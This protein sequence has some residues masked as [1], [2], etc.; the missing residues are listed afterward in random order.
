MSRA[1]APTA[2]FRNVERKL[3]RFFFRGL[4]VAEAEP[5]GF[6]LGR[7]PN[8]TATRRG[9][10]VGL[11]FG[12]EVPWGV[13]LGLGPN[14][15]LTGLGCRAG[16]GCGL[17]GAL[18]LSA[19]RCLAVSASASSMAFGSR[20][21]LDGGFIASLSLASILGWLGKWAGEGHL[22]LWTGGLK[23]AFELRGS[24]CCRGCEALSSGNDWGST[25]T[26]VEPVERRGP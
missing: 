6:V 15:S 20:G 26:A 24:R 9:F 23:S 7:G 17:G 13:A 3:P 8:P 2:I 18:G 10:F 16:S 4:G 1:T 19:A 14:P 22:S 12:D 5:S 25:E 11:G 21:D